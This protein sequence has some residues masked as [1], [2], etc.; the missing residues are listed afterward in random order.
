LGDENVPVPVVPEDFVEV[1]LLL[2]LVALLLL[3]AIVAGSSA[4]EAASARLNRGRLRHLAAEDVPMA[5]S[6]LEL[7][8]HGAPLETSLAVANATAVVLAAVTLVLMAAQVVGIAG[9]VGYALVVVGV[10]LLLWV[11]A[12]FRTLGARRPEGILILLRA[13]LLVV[14]S[15]FTPLTLAIAW[16]TRV[17]FPED[18][19]AFGWKDSGL[20]EELRMMADAADKDGGLEEKEKE[21]IAS[22][23]TLGERTAREIMV[24]R[25]DVAAVDAEE[26]LAVVLETIKSRG[27]SRVPIYEGTIDNVVGIVYAKDLLRHMQSGSLDQPSRVLARP[28]HFIPESKKIDELLRDM[29]R[30]KVHI[31]IVVD[32]YGGTAGLVT[33]EDLLEEI[34]GEIQDE[35]DM[36]E[37]PIEKHG[38]HE[39]IFDARVSI[40]DVNETLDILL[41]NGEYDTI[42]GLV[43]NRLGKIPVVGDRITLEGVSIAVLS[44]AGKRIKKVQVLVEPSGIAE[45]SS[46]G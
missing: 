10:I 44:T 43:Y 37:R 28:P 6:L 24:P 26:P 2:N 3:L 17:A 12:A 27:H 33:I 29:Q 42:G 30:R 45:R 13:P 38:D 19:D 22:I 25:V 39:A 16:L 5:R 46:G 11:Q 20:D 18:P 40:H 9:W 32:E 8:E 35:Y 21:M 34:V 1:D 31:A 36:E 23:F 41:T 14:R 7:L 15:I 4:A